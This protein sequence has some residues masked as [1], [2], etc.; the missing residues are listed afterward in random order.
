M[1]PFSQT[2]PKMIIEMLLWYRVNCKLLSLESESDSC[3][4]YMSG[5]SSTGTGVLRCSGCM[6]S[7]VQ[8]LLSTRQGCC[9]TVPTQGVMCYFAT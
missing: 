5:S 6:E 8:H 4:C 1:A 9:A 2:K 7:C 3:W